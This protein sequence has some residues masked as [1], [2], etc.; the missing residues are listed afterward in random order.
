MNKKQHIEK[1]LRRVPGAITKQNQIQICCP[2]HDD[3]NPSLDVSLVAIPGRVS[4]GGFNCFSCNASG[5]WNKLAAKLGLEG[6]GKPDPNRIDNVHENFL[7]ELEGVMVQRNLVYEKPKTEG[8]WDV[9]W[10][11]LPAQFLR[12]VGAEYLWDRNAEEY[13]VY[14]PIHSAMGKL[15]GHVA[16]RGE[17]SDIPARYKYLNSTGFEAKNH[18]YCLNYEKS[19]KVVVVVEGPYDTLKFRAEGI[20]AIGLLGVNQLSDQKIMQLIARGCRDVV[21]ALD[22]DEAGREATFKH[23]ERM[24]AVGLN[25]V[26]LNLSRYLTHPEQKMDPGNAPDQVL[27]D[28]RNFLL[29]SL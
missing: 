14:L 20:P 19:P 6:W 26:D 3:T 5:G 2:F 8:P 7:Y 13:R 15:V 10:R 17:P 16:A 18:W 23:A 11:G 22:A 21:L 24:K 29:R 1:Q 9:P 28:L 25:V 4:V 27:D 12:E